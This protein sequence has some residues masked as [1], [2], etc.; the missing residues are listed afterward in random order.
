MDLEKPSL[1]FVSVQPQDFD[2][3]SEL[4]KLR[5][6]HNNIGAVVSFVGLVRDIN[7]GDDVSVLELEHYPGM[8]EKVLEKIRLEAHQRWKL[9]ASLII[10]RIGKLYPADQIVLVA[11]ASQHRENAF[12]AAH[13]IMDYLKTNAPFWKKETLPNGEVRWVD[14]RVSDQEAKKRWAT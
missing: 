12:Y 1:P 8:T 13:F 5:Q 6:G 14:S 2:L 7:E 9:E 4:L 10:H 3:T 11:V